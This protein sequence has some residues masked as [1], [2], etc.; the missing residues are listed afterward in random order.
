ML[1]FKLFLENEEKSGT[2]NLGSF[3]SLENPKKSFPN[4]A[5]TIVAIYWLEQLEREFGK[6]PSGCRFSIETSPL[7]E[8]PFI[9]LKYRIKDKNSDCAKY[10]E[11]VFRN[12]ENIKHWTK[13]FRSTLVMA[14]E[15]LVMDPPETQTEEEKA[16][17]KKRAQDFLNNILRKKD[18][19]I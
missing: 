11:K 9:V 18:H 12:Y 14:Q 7:A 6:P 5:P 2:L 16:E 1:N 8:Y 10:T 13:E 4:V 17:S 3:P 15:P 19:E